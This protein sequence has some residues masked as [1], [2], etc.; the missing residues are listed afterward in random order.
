[1]VLSKGYRAKFFHPRTF[2]VMHWGTVTKVEEHRVRV[3]F[4]IDGRSY[5]T[6]KDN[7]GGQS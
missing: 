7:I 4:Q 2:G 3:K 1:M 6:H 5:W